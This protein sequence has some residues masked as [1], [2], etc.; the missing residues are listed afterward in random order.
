MK[1]F[2]LLAL[3]FF[4]IT[5]FAKN[6]YHAEF[7]EDQWN[8]SQEALAFLHQQKILDIQCKKSADTYRRCEIELGR[9]VTGGFFSQARYQS[10]TDFEGNTRVKLFP[11]YGK[12]SSYAAHEVRSLLDCD[13]CLVEVEKDCHCGW[14][15]GAFISENGKFQ[16]IFCV[17]Y[18]GMICPDEPVCGKNCGKKSKPVP[19]ID[20]AAEIR[21]IADDSAPSCIQPKKK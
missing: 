20:F 17:H 11:S 18:M 21:L 7:T 3:S 10:F 9:Y 4:A 16:V 6:V 13:D 12:W 1:R 2:S 19:T 15:K 14:P 8:C 5:S